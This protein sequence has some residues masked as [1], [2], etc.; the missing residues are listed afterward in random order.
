MADDTTGGL[1]AALQIP[2]GQGG[3][4]AAHDLP[5]CRVGYLVTTD[6]TLVPLQTTAALN[7]SDSLP[8]AFDE[9][10]FRIQVGQDTPN[11][12][13]EVILRCGSFSHLTSLNITASQTIYWAS[14]TLQALC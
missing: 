7:C 5:R 11:G 10:K 6:Q 12:R 4:F 8:N 9:Q 13:A 3:S 2:A 1:T 14:T